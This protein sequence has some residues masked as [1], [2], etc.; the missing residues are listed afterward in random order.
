MLRIR[1]EDFISEGSTLN[2]AKIARYPLAPPCP[3]E[4]YMNA[5]TKI[6]AKNKGKYVDDIIESK[7]IFSFFPNMNNETNVNKENQLS[8][9]TY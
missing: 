6:K 3:T 5:I 9:Y 1:A 2:N 7:V 8:N 4:A